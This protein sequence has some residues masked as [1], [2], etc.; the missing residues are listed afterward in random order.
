M[1]FNQRVA[2]AIGRGPIASCKMMRIG[3]PLRRRADSADSTS[4]A[5]TNEMGEA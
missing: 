4:P 5:M 1:N 3:R 2:V